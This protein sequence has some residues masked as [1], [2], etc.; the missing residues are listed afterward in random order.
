MGGI[1][2]ISRGFSYMRRYIRVFLPYVLMVVS[3]FV[4]D[5]SIRLRVVMMSFG[6]YEVRYI[7]FT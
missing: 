1:G 6:F 7:N 2:S 5:I 4:R 3:I